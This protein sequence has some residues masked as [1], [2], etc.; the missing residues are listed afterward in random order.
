VC[1]TTG[2]GHESPQHPLH[3]DSRLTHQA[4]PPGLTVGGPIDV[5]RDK[6]NWAQKIVAKYCFPEV[7]RWPTLEAYW[8]VFWYPPMC[9]FTIHSPMA[10]NAYAWGYLAGRK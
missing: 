8:D 1:Y 10:Q 5:A 9:E 7:Q 4:P 3:I 6:N 2:L